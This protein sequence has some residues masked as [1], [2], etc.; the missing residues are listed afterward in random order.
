MTKITNSQHIEINCYT[1][2]NDVFGSI[3]AKDLLQ[4]IDEEL[5]DIV[6]LVE[7]LEARG[8]KVKVPKG[9]YD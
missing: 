1:T 3:S 6:S 7:Y 4:Y 9:F 8:F 5:D 2:M